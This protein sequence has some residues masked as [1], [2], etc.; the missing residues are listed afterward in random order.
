VHFQT[1]RSS[2]QRSGAYT[3]SSDG[4]TLKSPARITGALGS[5]HIGVVPLQP[6][7]K[8]ERPACSD[9]EVNPVRPQRAPGGD[10][11]IGGSGSVSSVNLLSSSTAAKRCGYVLV[12][13]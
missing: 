13:S 6:V 2:T 12:P 11:A 4:I 1:G 5:A 9:L 10:P 8:A 3:L 7:A